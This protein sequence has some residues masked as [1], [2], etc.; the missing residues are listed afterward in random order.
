MRE[1]DDDRHGADAEGERPERGHEP[2]PDTALRDGWLLGRERHRRVHDACEACLV[3][4]VLSLARRVGDDYPVGVPGVCLDPLSA[5]EAE[6]AAPEHSLLAP[7]GDLDQLRV[8]H[9]LVDRHRY[10]GASWAGGV[11][12][13]ARPLRSY[14]VIAFQLLTT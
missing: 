7:L 8:A 12:H 10:R 9:D 2:Q 1:H 3:A 6:A 4:R 5:D 13:A 11:L 14:P